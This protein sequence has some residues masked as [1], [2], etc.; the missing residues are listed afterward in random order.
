M[1]EQ[2]LEVASQLITRNSFIHFLY[3]EQ[4]TLPPTPP[5]TLPA[6]TPPF[7]VPMTTTTPEPMPVDMEGNVTLS[8]L[9]LFQDCTPSIEARCTIPAGLPTGS[10][11]FIGCFTDLLTINRSAGVN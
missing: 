8:G 6:T 7:T 3:Q 11:Q 10:R 5:P 1:L 4:A 9:D 2:M